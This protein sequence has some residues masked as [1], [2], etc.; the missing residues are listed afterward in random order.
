[1]TMTIRESISCALRGGQTETIPIHCRIR[2]APLGSEGEWIRELGWGIM[3]H[4]PVFERRFKGCE[5]IVN[6]NIKDGEKYIHQVVKTNLGILQSLGKPYFHPRYPWSGAT[7]FLEYP[8][9]TS[10]DYP[11]ILSMINS[12][13][14]E[15]T[16]NEFVNIDSQIGKY[17]YCYCWAGYDPMHEIIL[18]IM[19]MEKFSYEW[20]DNRNQILE[21]YYALREKHREMYRLIA[22]CPAELVIYGGNIPTSFVS[23][24]MFEAYYL[25]CYEEFAE[26]LKEADKRIGAHLDDKSRR[27]SEMFTRCPWNVMEALAVKP[28]GDISV[29]DARNLWPNRVLSILFPSSVLYLSSVEIY[30]FAKQ[31]VKEAGLAKGFLISLTEEVPEEEKEKV[32]SNIARAIY[33]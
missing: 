13:Q 17:G 27:L 7:I 26:I 20:T 5:V 10:N 18:E 28:D 25:P 4:P 8:F 16:F 31:L 21:L 1:M 6:E 33:E 30:E 11:A 32:F 24:K 2:F 3:D 15:A 19:G 9:K 29:T 22:K 23:P 12:I 14:Y